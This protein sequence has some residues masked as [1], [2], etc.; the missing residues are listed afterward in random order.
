LKEGWSEVRQGLIKGFSDPLPPLIN[1]L[2]LDQLQPRSGLAK[3]QGIKER[4]TWD[5]TE[6]NRRSN[7]GITWNTG[8]LSGVNPLLPPHRLADLDRA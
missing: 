1:R 7:R 4:L 2:G 5:D 8:D 6:T 3:G